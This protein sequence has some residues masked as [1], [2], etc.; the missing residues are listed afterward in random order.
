M[1]KA[2]PRDEG[3]ACQNWE[4]AAMKGHVEARRNLGIS[5][6]RKWNLQRAARHYVI[7]AKMGD[8]ECLDFIKKMFARGQV[9][10]RQ[11][12]KES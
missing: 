6:T 3:R 4:V 7:A 8:Q 9:T 2:V 5:E 12:G 10:K 1:G 11:Y